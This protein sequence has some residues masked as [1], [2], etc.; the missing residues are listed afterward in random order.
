MTLTSR[1]TFA[2]V[3][4]VGIV[5]TGLLVAAVSS[6]GYGTLATAIW[7]VGYGLMVLVLWWGWLRPLDLGHDGAE[8]DGSER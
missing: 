2:L 3:L 6:A 5:G 4:A 1:P 8:T 7:I